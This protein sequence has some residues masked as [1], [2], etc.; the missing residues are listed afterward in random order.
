MPRLSHDTP[1]IHPDCEIS[2]ATFGTFTEVGRGSRMSH[3][4]LGD[5]SY[6]DRYADIANTDVGKFS[7][8]AAFVRIG[9]TDHPM[10]KASLHH[11]HYRSGDYF[12][13]TPH[14]EAWFA[15]RRSRRTYIG[16]DT[17]LG[18]AAQVRPD[19]TIGHG[20]VIAGGAIVTKDVA[21]YMIV[22]GIPAVP[23]RARFTPDVAERLMAL[24]WWDWPHERLHAA[25]DDFR[26]LNAEAFLEKFG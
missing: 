21:P 10:T 6:C 2:D 11:F 12:D 13:D 3:S 22:A 15:H 25:L 23:I 17:W 7:N 14:D 9:A 8:I 1:F 19:V 20:A 18:H 24:A 16:H 5:Y 4:H 26:S